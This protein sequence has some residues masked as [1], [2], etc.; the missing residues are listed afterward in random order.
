MNTLAEPEIINLG[1]ESY[2]IYVGSGLIQ[3]MGSI[4]KDRISS[5]RL[6]VI[7][8][9]P[10]ID[11]HGKHI[12]S[13]LHDVDLSY[14]LILV[15]DGEKA[16]T[17]LAA[18]DLIGKLLELDLDRRSILLAFGGGAVGD[19]TGSVASIF[20]RGIRYIQVPTTL[21]AQVDSSLGG[22]TA[23]NHPK[24]KNLIGSFHQPIMVISDTELI[25][26][27]PK[28]EILSG[29]AE[30][31]KHGVVSDVS[32]FKYVENNIEGLVGADQE[33]LI[34]V[35]K[36]SVAIKGSYIERDVL[37]EKGHRAALNY[38]HTL[39]HSLE[40]NSGLDL[41][42]GEAVARGML[43]ASRL[44]ILLGLMDEK[45]MERQIKLLE[46]IGFDLGPIDVPISDLMK[47]MHKDKKADEGSI[48]FVLP[49]GI[50]KPP[51]LRAV[52]DEV[53]REALRKEG[54]G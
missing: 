53:V 4:V 46:G 52:D 1:E 14:T 25:E 51:I 49:T 23:V 27:L 31:V 29:L 15:P 6:I 19:L 43:F 20:L 34:R 54:Y 33:S 47:T 48:R 3:K 9:S 41:R 50:G 21:L 45:D 2:P 18:E 24:G 35:I 16:K 37:D 38:G 7:S 28:R 5:S 8:S 12:T 42:H 10:I 36:A 11:V 44:S 30:V 22:K 26:T 39:G 17:W 13:S 32:L 40:V